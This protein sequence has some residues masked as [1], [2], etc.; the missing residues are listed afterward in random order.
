MAAP[1]HCRRHVDARYVGVSLVRGVGPRVSLHSARAGRPALR[2]EP[3]HPAAAR[4]VHASRTASSPR[5]SGRFGD[6]N[7]PVHAWAAWRVYKI[8]KRITGRADR[9]VPRTGLPQAAAQFHVVGE[10][11]GQRGA[12]RL[13]GR[14]PRVR[15]YRSLRPQLAAADRRAP[16]AV[17]R[18]RLDGHVLPEY[19]DDRPGIGARE[20][21][22]RGCR[23]QVLRALPVHRRA[24][25]TTSAGDGIALW[26]EEDEFFYDVLHMPDDSAR[27]AQGALAG[28]LHPAPGGGDDRARSAGHAAGAS[29]HASSGSSNTSRIWRA[30]CR[31]G[32]SRAWKS[33]ACW[34]W[35]AAIA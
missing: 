22:V 33:A 32:T 10:P 12:Q 29:R 17:G 31:A 11:Q 8:E 21:R 34:R 16:R 23:H 1:Q 4:V 19:A 3:A 14:L 9:D 5:T 25:S 26:D 20:P 6:V 28:R 30:W 13:P 35:C 24:R 18:N 27:A 15:Q 2:Q 7:P